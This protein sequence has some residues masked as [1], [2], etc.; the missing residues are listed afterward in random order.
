MSVVPIN[1]VGAS[2]K[3]RSEQLND[4]RT[5][6]MWPEYNEEAREVISLQPTAGT[7]AFADGSS[8]DR[9]FGVHNSELYQV[10]GTDQ[11]NT[12]N[13]CLLYTSDAADE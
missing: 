2:S 9:G 10:Y 7:V 6:N 4:Q 12:P 8:S 11:P 1:I 13:T 3:H 5:L